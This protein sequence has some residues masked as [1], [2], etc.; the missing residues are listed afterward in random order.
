[1]IIINFK[2]IIN[3]IK[4]ILNIIKH[5]NRINKI[6]F[7]INKI[8]NINTKLNKTDILINILISI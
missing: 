8:L 2:I 6:P 7:N 3:I 4:Y 5:N 1:M